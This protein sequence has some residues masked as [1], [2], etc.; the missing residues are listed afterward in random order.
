LGGAAPARGVDSSGHNALGGNVRSSLYE[1]TVFSAKALPDLSRALFCDECFGASA[2][3]DT[4]C[5]QIQEVE[6]EIVG[7]AK[8]Y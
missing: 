4:A 1:D 2:G 6:Q 7:G 5:L 8:D 3:A